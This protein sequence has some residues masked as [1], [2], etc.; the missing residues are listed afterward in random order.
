MGRGVVGVTDAVVGARDHRVVDDGHGPDRRPTVL[1]RHLGLG[2]R[3]SHEQFVVHAGSYRPARL[4]RRTRERLPPSTRAQPPDRT[5]AIPR[6]LDVIG[7][8]RLGLGRTMPP[9]R[10][11]RSCPAG[12]KS[13][14]RSPRSA[15]PPA[16][17]PPARP[18]APGQC[19]DPCDAA[20]AE[21]ERVLVLDHS[22]AAVGQHPALGRAA[23]QGLDQP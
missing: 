21:A 10:T 12:G 19:P 18:P 22:A 6:H 9:G 23:G 20:P 4:G 2:Q 16:A 5:R 15:P 17:Q 1:E 7:V 13:R 3:L 8:V 14:P 11:C